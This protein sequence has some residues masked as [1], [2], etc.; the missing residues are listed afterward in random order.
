VRSLFSHLLISAI[1]TITLAGAVPQHGSAQPIP[2]FY[3]TGKGASAE[4]LVE[5]VH[6]FHC[7]P[8][9]GWDPAAGV[10]HLHS[11]EGICKNFQ[12]CW[13]E[14]ERCNFILGRGWGYWEWER[15]GWDNWRFTSCMMRAGCY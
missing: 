6:G 12:R 5:N 15:Y 10:Y 1:V 7:R 11:H 9:L 8:V 4:A 2:G 14:Y 13:H 3:L